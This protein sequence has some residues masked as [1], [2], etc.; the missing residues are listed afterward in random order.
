MRHIP[1]N[2]NIEGTI[3]LDAVFSFKISK[4]IKVANIILVSRCVVDGEFVQNMSSGKFVCP[5]GVNLRLWGA[6]EDVGE[7]K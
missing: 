2:R 3:L 6:R 5:H 7:L 4:P 1:T